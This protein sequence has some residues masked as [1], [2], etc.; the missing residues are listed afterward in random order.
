M[1]VPDLP[2]RMAI[3]ATDTHECEIDFTYQFT[4]FV[5]IVS[6]ETET[7]SQF[8]GCEMECEWHNN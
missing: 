8:G 5:I 2:H 3:S 6:C 4:Q 1:Y 7:Q